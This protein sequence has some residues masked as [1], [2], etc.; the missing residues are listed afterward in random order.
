VTAAPSTDVLGALRSLVGILSA[1]QRRRLWLA[2]VGAAGL[3]VLDLAALGLLAP[4]T[5]LLLTPDSPGGLAER[6]MDMTGIEDPERLAAVLGVAIVALFVVRAVASVAYQWWNAGFVYRVDAD[7]AGRLI[8]SYLAAPY[9]FHVDH[10]SAELVRNV[11]DNVQAAI[12]LGLYGLLN[13][14]TEVFVLAAVL[15]LLAVTDLP[16]TLGLAVYFVLVIAVYERLVRARVRRV[17]D[18]YHAL[19]HRQYQALLHA[20]GGV[21]EVY[22]ANAQQHFGDDLQAT[23]AQMAAES[24]KVAVF[25]TLPRYYLEVA[26][27]IGLGA[28]AG[29]LVAGAGSEAAMASLA[30]F[31]G[32]GF[33]ALPSFGRLL[34]VS[35]QVRSYLPA[36]ETVVDDVDR[37]AT[38]DGPPARLVLPEGEPVVAVRDLSFGYQA[39]EPVLE[40]VSFS[41]RRGRS[42]GI[43]GASG[44]GKTT[45]L[46]L[47][48]GLYDPVAGEVLVGGR[49]VGSVAPEWRAAV[50]YVPQDVFLVDAS[51]RQ[52]LAFGLA[53]ADIDEAAV[54]EAAEQAELAAWIRTLPAGLDT[55]VGERGVRLSGGQ[56]QRVG[57][58]R[59]L[60]RRPDVL[61]LDE[62]TA[63]LDVE[64]EA[65]ITATVDRLR[66][67]LTT[68][69]VAHRL[70]TVRRCDA[71]CLLEEGRVAS[72]GAFDEL[73]RSSTAFDR[74]ASLAGI[75]AADPEQ[76]A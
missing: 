35:N 38:V 71:I 29:V 12:G 24:R 2:V 48:L 59:A 23:R 34:Q 20:L 16:V 61:V 39:D 37:F 56:R 52:N 14:V 46:D 51:L 49:P 31:V 53:P 63:S 27:V 26:L 67:D 17:A 1:A 15:V 75:A 22:V 64:T 3:A 10:A 60:Y 74:L 7:V 18:R 65:R 50:G 6:A 72:I 55:E 45:L 62:A 58:A 57:L 13:L 76:V 4:L 19:L 54:W 47:M 9:R 66:G 41:V 28:A 30:V 5:N 25:G 68:I 11:R 69:V 36:I 33:R 42:F 21:K 43:V 70:S 44:A 32:A 40:D 8:G 73:R